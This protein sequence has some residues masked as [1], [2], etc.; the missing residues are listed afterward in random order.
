[1]SNEEII[2]ILTEQYHSKKNKTDTEK[3]CNGCK[4]IKVSSEYA[5][6]SKRKDGSTKYRAKCRSCN[7]LYNKKRYEISGED[8]KLKQYLKYH[9]NKKKSNKIIDT[10]DSINE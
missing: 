7:S 8:Q 2:K 4:E 3:K 9:L 5:I 6:H 1:M 10:L